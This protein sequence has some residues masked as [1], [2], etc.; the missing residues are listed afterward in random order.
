MALLPFKTT[1]VILTRNEGPRLARAVR[2]VLAQTTTDPFELL[3]VDSSSTDGSLTCLEGTPARKLII[4]ADSFS[5][6][7]TRNIAVQA[8]R[9]AY[10][11]FIVADAAPVGR[12]WLQPLVDALDQFP[13]AA[14]AYGRQRAW[15]NA[16]P[17]LRRRT[18]AWTPPGPRPV[19]KRMDSP[20]AFERLP[21]LERIRLAAFDNVNSIVRRSEVLEHPFPAVPFGEDILWGRDRLRAGRA[22]VY[23]PA[24][25]VWHSHRRS[26]RD[27]LLRAR[28][29]HALLAREFGLLAVPSLTR[30]AL[31][32]AGAIRSAPRDGW[33]ATSRQLAELTGQYLAGRT[34]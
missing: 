29:E 11:A 8:A 7:T 1:V 22:L 32:A 10:V 16:D 13:D 27:H 9:G 25:E 28:V 6:G 33:T 5:H 31:L 23:V 20:D 30:L 21:P 24:A 19:V 2:G 15:P 17:A 4:P 12:H 14:G 3:V 18:E 34:R 26:P